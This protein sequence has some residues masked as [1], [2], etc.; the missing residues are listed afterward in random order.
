MTVSGSERS[1]STPRTSVNS[2]SLLARSAPAIAPAKWSAFMLKVSPPRP[3]AMGAITGM[4]PCE[5]SPDT[6]SGLTVSTSPTN[7]R[8]VGPERFRAMTIPPSFPLRPMAR[9]PCC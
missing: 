4:K 7:P 5:I 2:T 3:A 1:F 8:S 6:R 9:P